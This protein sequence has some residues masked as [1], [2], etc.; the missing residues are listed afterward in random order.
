MSPKIEL[1]FTYQQQLCNSAKTLPTLLTNEESPDSS[2]VNEK[3]NS[4]QA[5]IFVKH[6]LS[7][8]A[9]F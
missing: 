5:F 9:P 6:F 3:E 2:L 7:I 8:L 1:A 4:R